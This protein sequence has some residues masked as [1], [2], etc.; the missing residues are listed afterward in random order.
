M[1][2]KLANDLTMWYNKVRKNLLEEVWPPV[3]PSSVIYVSMIKSKGVQT[4]RELIQILKECESTAF[5]GDKL[6]SCVSDI[7]KVFTANPEVKTIRG[8]TFGKPPRRILIE[9]AA[10]IGKTLLTKEIVFSWVNGTILKDF[11]LVF[12]VCL[13][14]P[15]VHE[16]E[17][18]KD[19]LQ[20]FT[21]NEVPY[22]LENY[23]LGAGGE[24]IAF[25]FDGINEYPSPLQKSNTLIMQIIKG[26]VFQQSTVVVTSRPTT[27]V[28]LHSI[29]DR[30]IE[31]LGLPK[32]ETTILSR[33]FVMHL[34]RKCN[35]TIT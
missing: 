21:G 13:G 18:I 3:Q 17:T 32:N 10:G 16:V 11:K 24:N 31:I 9:G 2:D 28:F 5:T 23:I 35:W 19:L 33:C 30:R 4:Q 27:T 34:K 29:F 14:D 6:N 20:I 1:V 15:R 12:L 8:T 22:D 25:V 26:E 7:S